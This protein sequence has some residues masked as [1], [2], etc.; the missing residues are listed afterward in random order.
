[1]LA[2]PYLY[3]VPCLWCLIFSTYSLDIVTNMWHLGSNGALFVPLPSQPCSNMFNFHFFYTDASH[4]LYFRQLNDLTIMTFHCTLLKC[5]EYYVHFYYKEMQLPVAHL[6]TMP[7][8]TLWQWLSCR[9]MAAGAIFVHSANLINNY[10]FSC[11]TYSSLM[12][13]YINPF[14][15]SFALQYLAGGMIELKKDKFSYIRD[16]S[17]V[18]PI[19]VH[20]DYF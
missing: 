13:T 6:C 14:L 12:S 4:Y 5:T 16:L 20:Q 3:L 11:R 10:K 19:K 18:T 7:M 2:D 8:C 17:G 15:S 1:M 9:A